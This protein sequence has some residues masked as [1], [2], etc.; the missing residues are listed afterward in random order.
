[1]KSAI[2]IKNCLWVK[3]WVYGRCCLQCTSMKRVTPGL[4]KSFFCTSCTTL[5]EDSMEPIENLSDG[6][7]TVNKFCYLGDKLITGGGC[8]ASGP[9]L[10]QE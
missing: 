10:Q 7:E 9:Q 4:A 2:L 3:M 8:E 1:M 6:V 5:D